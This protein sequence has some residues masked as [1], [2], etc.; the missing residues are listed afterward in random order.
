MKGT[1]NGTPG[2]WKHLSLPL[3][4]LI[5]NDFIMIREM[6]SVTETIEWPGTTGREADETPWEGVLSFR[7]ADLTGQSLPISLASRVCVLLRGS[8]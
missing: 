7:L 4:R 8:W 1:F 5:L 3:C 2:P 6:C